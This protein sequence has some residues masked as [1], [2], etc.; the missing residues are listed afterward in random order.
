NAI[1][2]G[3]YGVVKD[4]YVI[5]ADRRNIGQ[6]D[7]F[8][9]ARTVDEILIYGQ[10]DREVKDR[11]QRYNPVIINTGDRYEN[12]V[13]IVRRF[14]KIH[15]TQQVLLSNGEFI[16]QQL[17]AGNEP[18]VFIGSANVPDV[19]KDFVHDTNIKV[20]VLIGNELITTAT[21]IRRDLGISVFVKFAQGARVPTAGVSN[22]EDLDRFPLPR[23]ILRLSL[24]SLKYN[25]ATGQLEVTYH[26]DVDVGTYFKGTITVRDDAGTQTVGDIN[27][28]FIDGD[29]FRTVV[30]DVNPL[31]GQNITA[32]L[33]TIFGESPKSLEYSLRQTV[34]IEQVKVEDSSKLE[35]VGAV[36]SGSDSAFEVKVRNIGE[37]DLFAQAEIVELT[38][39]G[40]LHSYGSKSV[41]FVEKGK[42]KTIPVE[43]ADLTERYGQRETSLIH[44]VE[45][46]FAF[47][48]RKAGLIVYVLVAVLALLLLLILLRSRKCRHCGAHN[49]VFGSTCR[50]CKASLR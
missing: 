27:P 13:E 3:P 22:V 26:N 43:V 18:I 25:S 39:N 6:I 5:F 46:E 17:L 29:E 37:V 14:L 20:G 49:P 10:V 35:L 36:Y 21:A 40:E 42:T 33:F 24:S 47:S 45:G 30:Y 31:T 1:S 11:L 16:E 12:N 38:V 2:V 44:V 41:V 28:I 15:G 19:I 34:A 9:Q 4:S 50:K 8:L 48:V 23:V 32:E 7:A